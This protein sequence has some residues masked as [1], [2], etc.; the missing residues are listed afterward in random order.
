M[1]RPLPPGARLALGALAC[2]P[3]GAAAGLLATPTPT[4]TPTPTATPTITSTPTPAI[5]ADWLQFTSQ[6]MGLTLFYPPG[7]DANSTIRTSSWRT[8]QTTCTWKRG[9]SMRLPRPE[10]TSDTSQG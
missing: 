7:W 10:R 5:P 8:G 4:H 1:N 3:L 9:S 2:S 6:Y